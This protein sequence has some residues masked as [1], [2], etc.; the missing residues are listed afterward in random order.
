MTSPDRFTIEDQITQRLSDV[1]RTTWLS[2]SDTLR[3]SLILAAGFMD[4]EV[5]VRNIR[6]INN[7]KNR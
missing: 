2:L 3:R 1:E 4:V 5:A 7:L 6:E